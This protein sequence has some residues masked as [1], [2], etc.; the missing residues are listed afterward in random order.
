MSI[1]ARKINAH[2]LSSVLAGTILEW[3]DF[4]LFGILTP[5]I[6]VLFFHLKNSFLA[7]LITFGVFAVGFVMRPIGGFIFGYIGD[8]HGRKTALSLSVIF[9]A[10]PTCLIGLLPTWHEI[11]I[12][13]PVL[14][15]ILRLIQ[16]L[17]AS[18]EYPGAVCFLAEY[19]SN[20]HRGFFTSL[21]VFGVSGGILLG[22]FISFLTSYF[23][24]ADQMQ[25]WGWRVCFLLSLPLGLIGFYLRYKISESK[26]FT[27][28]D[29]KYKKFFKNGSKNNI[30]GAFRLT[31]MFALPM[32]CFYMITTYVVSFL[33]SVGK[34]PLHLGL[35]SNVVSLLM[36][37]F[38]VPLCGYISDKTNRKWMM[39]IGAVC[40]LVFS[41]PIFNYLI[42]GSVYGLF[43]GQA[44]L[45]LFIA[46]VMGPMT[47]FS[48]E[49]F[50]TFDRYSG[51]SIALNIAASAFGGTTPLISAFLVHYFRNPVTP[52]LYIILM[53]FLSILV[54]L[55]LSNHQEKSLSEI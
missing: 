18:G 50:S 40:L 2:F 31:L 55:S 9:M 34:V 36:Y 45:M 35:M 19:S 49:S 17:A 21:S 12:Y 44:L 27:E 13:A 25:V 20:K 54:T 23:L 33:A 52:C 16:G 32:V 43:I 53:S 42:S 22:S 24:T 10:L 11:G 14:L 38:L 5:V 26:I 7:L 15:I 41:Y 29:R 3:Y 37:I 30:L 46:I 1:A 48:T 47:A 6:S 39:V 28:S 4:S 8:R 51:V